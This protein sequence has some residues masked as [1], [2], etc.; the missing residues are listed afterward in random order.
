MLSLSYQRRAA[1][2]DTLPKIDREFQYKYYAY[3]YVEPL[4]YLSTHQQY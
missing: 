1:S 2:S 4:F 3:T